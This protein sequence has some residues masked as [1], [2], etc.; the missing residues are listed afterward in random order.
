[1]NLQCDREFKAVSIHSLLRRN[2]P[3]GNASQLV[4]ANSPSESLHAVRTSPGNRLRSHRLFNELV[5]HDLF[6]LNNPDAEPNREFLNNPD[7]RSIPEIPDNRRRDCPTLCW[8]LA[9]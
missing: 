8:L 9:D 2:L 3:I 5:E 7:W 4:I 6:D 1:M